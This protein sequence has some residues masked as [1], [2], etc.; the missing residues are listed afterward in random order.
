MKN[1][2]SENEESFL[3]LFEEQTR[4]GRRE[5]VVVIGSPHHQ[6]KTQSAVRPILFF[7]TRDRAKKAQC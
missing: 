6:L 1:V 2:L 7:R 5:A 3:F 4:R